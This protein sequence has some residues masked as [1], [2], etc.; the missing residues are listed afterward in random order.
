MLE[1]KGKLFRGA[2]LLPLTVGE[3]IGR[4]GAGACETGPPCAAPRRE[5]TSVLDTRMSRKGEIGL[6]TRPEVTLLSGGLD[7]GRGI[8][9]QDILTSPS[10]ALGMTGGFLAGAVVTGFP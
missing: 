2:S 7:D 9:S 1:D 5:V 4:R 8:S 6:G 10:L 3:D